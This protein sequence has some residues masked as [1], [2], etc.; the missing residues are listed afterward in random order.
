[1]RECGYLSYNWTLGYCSCAYKE[2]A[3]QDQGM[4]EYGM[5]EATLRDYCPEDALRDREGNKVCYIK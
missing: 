2:H 4:L 1:M 3:L 5:G